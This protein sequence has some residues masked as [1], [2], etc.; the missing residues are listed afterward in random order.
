MKVIEI[1]VAKKETKIITGLLPSPVSQLLPGTESKVL[2][3]ISDDVVPS[4]RIATERS[5]K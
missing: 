2:S 1:F 5:Q 4:S 3:I